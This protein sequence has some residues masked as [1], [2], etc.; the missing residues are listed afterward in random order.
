MGGSVVPERAIAA[1]RSSCGQIIGAFVGGP[2]A[3]WMGRRWSYVLFCVTSLISVVALYT[4][5]TSFG[6]ALLWLA[7]IAG[8]CTTTFFG[9]LPLYLPELFPTRIRATGEGIT[10]NF[11]RIIAAAGVVF[12]MGQLVVVFGGYA[13]AATIVAM[14]YILGL[15]LIWFA[16]ETKGQKL[17]D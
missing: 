13:K 16:P 9:W 17:P 15:A 12:G 7:M 3:E 5:V 4:C 8:I 11:G 1:M 10:F 6:P 14:V 2:M